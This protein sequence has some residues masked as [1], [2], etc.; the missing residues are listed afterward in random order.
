MR[1]RIKERTKN[2]ICIII[3]IIQG[4]N[5]GVCKYEKN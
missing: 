3:L 5:I 4:Q 2:N 1:D